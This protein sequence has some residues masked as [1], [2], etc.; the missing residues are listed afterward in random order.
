MRTVLGVSAIVLLFGIAD[1]SAEEKTS[2]T[3][4]VPNAQINV[5]YRRRPRFTRYNFPRGDVYRGSH[6]NDLN[7]GRGPYPERLTP[8]GV[9]TGPIPRSAR[10]GG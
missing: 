7:I 9:L 8:G 10:G 4:L 2:G 6:G 5:A 3:N 1:A